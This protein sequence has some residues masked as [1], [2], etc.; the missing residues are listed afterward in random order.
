MFTIINVETAAWQKPCVC[1]A[2]V[3]TLIIVNVGNYNVGNVTNNV[4]NNSCRFSG[5]SST[6]ETGQCW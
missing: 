2:A 5:N 4:G 1:H 3:S 6:A